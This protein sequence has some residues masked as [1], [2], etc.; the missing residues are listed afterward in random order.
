MSR[1][2]SPALREFGGAVAARVTRRRVRVALLVLVLAGT[3]PVG[4]T[5][6]SYQIYDG[7]END[8]G[9]DGP[10]PPTDGVTV[11]TVDGLGPGQIVA[12]HPNGS[13]L[14]KNTSWAV[15][16]DVDPA[17]EG[18]YTVEYVASGLADPSRCDAD[19]CSLSVIERVNL[20]TG[21]TERLWSRARPDM[22]SDDVH[23]VDRINET[24]FL[25]GDIAHPDSV[26]MVNV[27]TGA[28]TWRWNASDYYDRS[29]G[30]SY[31]GDFT[32]LNDVEYVEGGLVAVSV[33][34]MDSVVF[35]DPGEG[36]V[37]HRP[38]GGDGEH[39]T[40]YEQHN[41]D[42]IPAERG[43]PALLVA[44]SENNRIVEYERADGE[45][46]RT[47]RW[48]D[49]RMQ[50]PRDAD[51]LPNGHTLITDTHSDRVFEVDEDGEVVWET[52]FPGPYEAERLDTG[53]ESSGGPAASEADLSNR[54]PD[55][56]IATNAGY[57]VM[58]VVPPLVLHSALYWLP[59]WITPIGATGLLFSASV[60]VLW[61]LGEGGRAALARVRE[62]KST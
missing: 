12:Y 45:W 41:P 29:A 11:V 26:Y 43:G 30:G 17:P 58:S 21:E 25:V 10:I 54:A 8:I 13:L 39:E 44:D 61:G 7:A 37:E 56:G 51:R 34:N 20:S 15:Y 50:W 49:A 47:W 55:A 3:V 19:R 2:P 52:R 32:H 60:L 16:H 57:A 62:A 40:L 46:E 14:Y 31:P 48:R 24:T 22:G 53:T 1:S 35:L 18:E 38:L 6:A 27:T 9:T 5:W 4:T 28:V 36:V 33:R 59:A 42:Y 23:D